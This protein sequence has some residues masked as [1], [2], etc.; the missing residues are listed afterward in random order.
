MTSSPSR[1]TRPLDVFNQQT[2]R[3]KSIGRRRHDK[4]PGNR[5]PQER[6]S[7]IP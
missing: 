7:E 3:T 2:L 5:G 6:I 4:D 1:R